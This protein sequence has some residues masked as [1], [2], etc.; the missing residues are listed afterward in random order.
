MLQVKVVSSPLSLSFNCLNY[1]YRVPRQLYF[2]S[3][4]VFFHLQERYTI[5]DFLSCY[6]YFF[7]FLDLLLGHKLGRVVAGFQ[8][9]DKGLEGLHFVVILKYLSKISKLTQKSYLNHSMRKDGTTNGV[10]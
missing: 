3:N 6:Y 4:R 1:F 9:S 10:T 5:L 7:E 8:M 2:I